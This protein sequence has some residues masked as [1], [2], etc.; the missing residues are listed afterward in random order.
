MKDCENKEVA[1]N[2]EQPTTEENK[3]FSETEIMN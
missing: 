1:I 3:S 2:I